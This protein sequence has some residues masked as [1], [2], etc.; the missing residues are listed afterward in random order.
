MRE[1]EESSLYVLLLSAACGRCMLDTLYA[2]QKDD[3]SHG[4]LN[5]IEER[6]P[7]KPVS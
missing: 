7:M 5:P 3:Q 4:L 6:S 2:E 1:L